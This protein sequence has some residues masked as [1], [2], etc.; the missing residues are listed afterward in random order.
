[1]RNLSIISRTYAS[2]FK[3]NVLIRPG[4][5]KK[6]MGIIVDFGGS[7]PQKLSG[8]AHFLEHKLYAK[9]TGDISKRIEDLGAST[10]AYTSY[11]ETMFYI[12]FLEHWRKLLPLLFELVG[13]THFTKENVA[14]ESKII[15]QELAM[16]QD[17]PN[18]K[19]SHDLLQRMYPDTNLAEDLTGTQASL[20][21]MSPSI[22]DEIYQKNYYTGNLEFIVS[23]G[24]TQG[25]A[26]S[27][28]REVGKLQD[29][30][31][32]H[33][34]KSMIKSEI[35]RPKKE[36]ENTIVGD[37]SVPLIGVGIRLPSLAS[38]TNLQT[39][40]T[41]LQVLLEMMLQIRLGP[42]SSWFENAQRNGIVS[43]PL[44][45]NVTHTRQGSFAT[46]LGASNKP[47][48]LLT[49]IKQQLKF[50]HILESSFNLQ[51]KN[52][53]AQNIRELD[54]IDDLAIEEAELA[55]DN[56]KR[57]NLLNKIQAM[58]FSEFCQIYEII[59]G[60]SEVFT[61]ILKG[62]SE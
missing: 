62:K 19:V 41:Q 57:E 7:D 23:G 47:E 36:R 21:K 37:V 11:N 14:K 18:W 10:N 13:S 22:L 27:I 29:N 48:E 31:F 38:L 16:Y 54:Q 58:S 5:N 24:F 51:K 17:D 43:L 2:G 44:S 42:S 30:Y 55:L 9:E 61:T 6:F 33:A 32:R 60:Q 53:I 15:S 50:G 45:I 49:E 59:L 26:K 35:V 52:Y 28:L 25:Q 20:K 39:S 4:F 8:G 1:M 56:E 12:E 3:A 46:V 40:P 34:K